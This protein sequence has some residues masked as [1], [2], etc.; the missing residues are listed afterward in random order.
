MANKKPIRRSQLITPFGVGA[1][2]DFRGADSLMT[3]GLDAW[4]FAFE[5]KSVCDELVIIEER[6]QAQLNVTHFRYPPAY[7]DK[8]SPF[9][10]KI[11]FVRFPSWH[12]C[13]DCG[14][15]QELGING[16]KTRC[17]CDPCSERPPLRRAWLLPVRLV[18]VCRMGHITD[19]PFRD[20]VHKG[21]V[22]NP[23]EHKIQWRARGSSGALA[24]VTLSCSCGKARTLEQAFNFNSETGGPLHRLEYDCPGA[25]PWFVDEGTRNSCGEFLRVVQRGASNVY[26]AATK[27]SIYLPAHGVDESEIFA[28]VV[29]QIVVQLRTRPKEKWQPFIDVNAAMK[30]LDPAKLS[31][32]VNRRLE[33]TNQTRKFLTEEEFR[34]EE[35]SVLAGNDLIPGNE[36]IMEEIP[37]QKYGD[38]AQFFSKVRL[39][40]KLRETRAL[41]GFSRLAPSDDG[42]GAPLQSIKKDQAIDWL[43]AVI[44]RGEGIFIEFDQNAIDTWLSSSS[45]VEKRA[46]RLYQVFSDSLRMP[47]AALQ[48]VHPRHMLIHTFAHA[49]I[50]EL[51]YECGYGSAS[52]RERLYCSTES[53][54]ESVMNGVL[55]YTAS[56]D[57]EGT[58]GGLV[59]QGKP[60]QFLNVVNAA[61]RRVRWCAVDPVCEE[62]RGQGTNNAN[63]AAC[64]SCSL[65]PETSCEEGNRILDRAMLVGNSHE[66]DLAFFKM[67]AAYYI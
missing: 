54:G 18:T 53:S 42:V 39:V 1:I 45:K 7:S 67:N 41:Y 25:R 47:I 29:E 26:F 2:V 65:L 44:V 10:G 50:R 36:L 40:K 27:S 61:L 9:Q 13:P 59:R 19:F 55:I 37:I 33:P 8:P 6:L 28:R 66:P 56:G 21:S 34:F 4:K 23:L 58:M 24:G 48:R 49:L 60:I 31:S 22:S 20:W 3:A 38:L 46:E 63:L 5:D 43:P 57:S 52:L 35:F 30:N 64:H 11:P 32:A 12:Y 16:S 51:V 17:A 62:S 14:W 15:M